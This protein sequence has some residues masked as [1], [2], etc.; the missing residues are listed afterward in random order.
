MNAAISHIEYC[1]PEKIVTNADID[2]EMPDWNVR[3][4]EEKVR[5]KKRHLAAADETALDLAVRACEKLFHATNEDAKNI[6]GLLFCTQSPDYFLP[7]NATLL[8]QRLK[9]AP[10]ILA[11]DFNAACSGFVLGLAMAQAFVSAGLLSRILLVTADTYSKYINPRDRS[12]RMIFGDGGAATLIVR[13]ERDNGIQHLDWSTHGEHHKKI[14]VPAGAARRPK[15]EQTAIERMDHQGNYRSEEN[16]FMDGNAVL[17]FVKT[18]V[19][20]NI[21]KFMQQH[22]L[23][24]DDI[25]AVIFHQGSGVVLD[26]LRDLLKIPPEKCFSNLESVGNLVSSSIPVALKDAW[27]S[28]IV[29]AGSRV[30]LAGFGVGLST[31]VALVTL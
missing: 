19:A 5:I 4:I 6:D 9:L 26:T 29:S 13:N 12:T 20:P 17:F 21:T 8:Q 7:G 1:L 10:S 3:I 22:A 30:L 15:C 25:D 18:T 11:Y 27:N 28:G 2:R 16:L 24:F 31:A 23:T 14:I